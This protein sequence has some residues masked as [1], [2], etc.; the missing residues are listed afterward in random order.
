MAHYRN[1]QYASREGDQYI[2]GQLLNSLSGRQSPPSSVSPMHPNTLKSPGGQS[3][4][5]NQQHTS[6]RGFL[7]T[8][9][10]SLLWP[11][12]N[13]LSELLGNAS[14]SPSSPPLGTS[15]LPMSPSH[16]PLT[17]CP[18]QAAPE[19][20]HREAGGL[21][22]KNEST[23]EESAAEREKEQDRTPNLQEPE[24]P[25]VSTASKQDSVQT[26]KEGTEENKKQQPQEEDP[27]T[28]PQSS[29]VQSAAKSEKDDM[30]RTD[31]QQRDSA[32]ASA[33]SHSPVDAKGEEEKKEGQKETSTDSSTAIGAPVPLSAV[34]SPS[35][36]L[37]SHGGPMNV[38]GMSAVSVPSRVP[39]SEGGEAAAVLLS[40][41]TAETVQ[42]LAQT[43]YASPLRPEKPEEEMHKGEKSE[44][45]N[46]E[47]EDPSSLPK[48]PQ[49]ACQ[50]PQ[51]PGEGGT[52]AGTQMVNES[53]RAD[54][55]TR[56]ET[57]EVGEMKQSKEKG[58]EEKE[59]TDRSRQQKGERKA[60][61][62]RRGENSVLSSGGTSLHSLQSRR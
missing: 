21:S 52:E 22:K 45:E 55:Q 17:I 1:S 46:A 13:Q 36:L 49:A 16:H 38:S 34:L 44:E 7:S 40:H 42:P 6:S 23:S 28:D 32:A 62:T 24:P 11:Y 56:F 47:K 43:Q 15:P 61:A 4:K 26:E 51:Q 30:V 35:S 31:G 19:E 10:D 18:E 48:S 25:N 12:L 20:G 5:Q 2:Y 39:P 58:E 29:S 57:E 41:S 37:P 33:S 3:V 9:D 59:K 60:Y 27:P 54:P 50:S 53:I 8:Q 14:P